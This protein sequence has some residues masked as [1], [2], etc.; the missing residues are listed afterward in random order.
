MKVYRLKNLELSSQVVPC[1][2]GQYHHSCLHKCIII[3]AAVSFI[4]LAPSCFAVRVRRKGRTLYEVDADESDALDNQ[5]EI[6]S[7]MSKNS[8]STTSLM[9]LEL[10]EFIYSQ[11]N[12]YRFGLQ[13]DGNLVLLD[14]DKTLWN[15]KTHRKGVTHA[16]L[17][18]DGN[19]VVVSSK[20][21]GP[22]W[23][24]GTTGESLGVLSF[25]VGNDG[26]ATLTCSVRGHLWSHVMANHDYRSVDATTLQGKVMAGYQGWFFAKGDGGRD[27][28]RHWSSKN[29]LPDKDSINIDFWPDLREF[30]D[31]E[32]YPTAFKYRDG[33]NAKLYSNYNQKTVERHCRWMYEYGIDGVFVQRFLHSAC[34]HTNAVDAKLLNV[35]RGTEKYGR[36]F[37]N[38]YDISG[39]INS[40]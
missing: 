23:T 15:A 21:K 40:D 29:Q 8:S 18:S 6:T 32:L 2:R 34:A 28:W 14:G 31:D 7:P 19:F 13:R 9:Q 27:K 5:I 11:N 37:V 20:T 4:L 16:E 1:I 38:M 33:S 39:V 10:G 36:L 24:T 12:R 17:Q 25:Q 3:I 35:M 22:V 26:I 30:D